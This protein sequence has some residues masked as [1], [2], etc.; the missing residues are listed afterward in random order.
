AVLADLDADV[1][2][3][4]PDFRTSLRARLAELKGKLHLPSLPTGDAGIAATGAGLAAGLTL[5]T[6]PT[7]ELDLT[8]LP[9]EVELKLATH[10]DGLRL[11]VELAELQKRFKPQL[12]A[13]PTLKAS[14][15]TLK[16]NIDNNL[17]ALT[18]PDLRARLAD[19]REKLIVLTVPAQSTPTEISMQ[20]DRARLRLEL[21]DLEATY[22]ILLP[23][24]PT[25]QAEYTEL[26]QALANNPDRPEE[27][28]IL[29]RRLVTLRDQLAIL[30]IRATRSS[31]AAPSPAQATPRTAAPLTLDPDTQ[32]DLV[33]LRDEMILAAT[34]PFQQRVMQQ[35]FSLSRDNHDWLWHITLTITTAAYGYGFNRAAIFLNENTDGTYLRGIL[36]IGNFDYVEAL[37]AWDD[38]PSLDFDTYIT[39]LREDPARPY[40]D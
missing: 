9:P 13:D 1:D 8:A 18:L 28:T 17:D 34:D 24:Q 12:A 35:M 27:L 22:G 25:L 5:P 11:Q 40:T 39:Y 31:D 16:A 3:Q 19:L 38:K 14:F 26:Q 32:A 33:M 20:A 29:W 2:T 23:E 21:H 4:S 10:Y 37:D 7:G 36:G 15:T 30:S 6:L